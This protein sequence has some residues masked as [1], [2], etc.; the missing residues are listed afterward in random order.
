MEI[1][2]SFF[3]LHVDVSIIEGINDTATG[4]T[5]GPIDMGGRLKAVEIKY[6]LN[7]DNKNYVNIFERNSK[8]Y[9]F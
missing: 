1:A 7:F 9:K 8:H 2:Q 3:D 5:T 6:R 4:G